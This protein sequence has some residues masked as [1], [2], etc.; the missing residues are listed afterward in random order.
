[1]FSEKLPFTLI[2]PV[3][4]CPS[5]I[6]ETVIQVKRGLE[7]KIQA[8]EVI[9][10]DDGSKDETKKILEKLIQGEKKFKLISYPKNQGKGFAVKKGILSASGEIIFFTDADLPF[11]INPILEGYELIKKENCDLILGK[12]SSNSWQ[13]WKRKLASRI[14]S[15]LVNKLFSLGIFDTQCGLKGFKRE[16]AKKIFEKSKIKRFA[17]DVEI[18]HLAKKHNFSIKI[19]PVKT[20]SF[21]SFS[22]VSLFPHSLKMLF[23]IIVI[24]LNSLLGKYR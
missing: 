13:G 17:F 16:V 11:G 2:I 15:F 24:K 5:F 1:M 19:F 21:S 8:Y 6:E 12:R 3:Y 4:N 14:F 18:L 9:F 23:D 20:V 7:E 10:V 22:T